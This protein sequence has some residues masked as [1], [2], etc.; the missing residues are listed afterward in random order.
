[1]L[2]PKRT[3]FVI[4][5]SSPH[6]RQ[7]FSSCNDLHFYPFS[8]SS[9]GDQHHPSA[10]DDNQHHSSFSPLNRMHIT[11]TSLVALCSKDSFVPST[12]HRHHEPA[13]NKRRLLSIKLKNPRFRGFLF[14]LA[15]QQNHLE[16]VSY[17]MSLCH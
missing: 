10:T 16:I 14:L 5:V 1:M 15:F 13:C 2:L 4:H 17:I 9:S 8:S 6:P 12:C 3:S 11:S 7:S